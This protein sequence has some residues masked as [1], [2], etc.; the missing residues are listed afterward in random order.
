[1]VIGKFDFIITLLAAT[2]LNKPLHSYVELVILV[3]S[4]VG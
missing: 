4:N 3:K 2:N 1:M